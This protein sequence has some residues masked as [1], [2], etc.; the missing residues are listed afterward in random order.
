[1][2][3]GKIK[4]V[5]IFCIFFIFSLSPFICYGLNS[6]AFAEST[7]DLNKM[8]NISGSNEEN[9]EKNKVEQTQLLRCD[10][11]FSNLLSPFCTEARNLF[12]YGSLLS[13]G[14]YLS[15]ADTSNKV[16]INTIKE[17]PL[18]DSAT[19][20]G[21]IGLGFLNAT[22][23]IHQSIWGEIHNAE[24]MAEA[25]AYAGVITWVL[26]RAVSEGR[27]GNPNDTRSFP[28]GHTSMAFAFS[29]VV[30]ARHGI[31]WG[32]LAYATALFIAYSRIH[33]DYHYLHDV[34]FGATLGMS[35]GLGI[36]YNHKLGHPYWL[37]PAP[38]EDGK[39]GQMIIRV[40]F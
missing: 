36:H 22:Y 12:I 33:D 26:K 9:K 34:V 18:R 6:T 25:S 14:I 7:K 37:M 29:S 28:S 16:R 35:Y 27:P 21:I 39:G 10:G 20:G 5:F 17:K 15:R 4:L 13:A 38:T 31:W 2:I 1:M 23:V 32:S 11:H 3:N 40:P 19:V 30:G 8:E 24:L